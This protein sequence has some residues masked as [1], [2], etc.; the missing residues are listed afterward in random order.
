M[1]K[2]RKPLKTEEEEKKAR[3]KSGKRGQS[4]GK[5]EEK[6]PT[7]KKLK[8]KSSKERAWSN[9]QGKEKTAKES[10][11]EKKPKDRKELA[12]PKKCPGDYA[13]FTKLCGDEVL[14]GKKVTD[15]S[16]RS[17]LISEAYKKITDA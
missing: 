2:D 17:G 5:E 11:G 15:I 9:S 4:Q 3:S 14:K 10:K 16:E 1:K 6:K 12:K 7:G 13:L 8:E